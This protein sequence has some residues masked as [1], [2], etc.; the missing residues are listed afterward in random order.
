[1][2]SSDYTTGIL[3]FPPAD[4]VHKARHTIFGHRVAPPNVSDIDRGV[5][6]PR[7]SSYY[8]GVSALGTRHV[9]YSLER[10]PLADCLRRPAERTSTADAAEEPSYTYRILT[11]PNVSNTITLHV[12][13]TPGAQKDRFTWSRNKL[14]VNA[15]LV[16]FK[17]FQRPA[18]HVQNV[19]VQTLDA[20]VCAPRSVAP[21]PPPPTRTRP[22]VD[23]SLRIDGPDTDGYW[24]VEMIRRRLPIWLSE[25][26][27]HVPLEYPKRTR[28]F[29]LDDLTSITPCD[30]ERAYCRMYDLG[31]EYQEANEDRSPGTLCFDGAP[32]DEEACLPPREG[33]LFTVNTGVLTPPVLEQAGAAKRS[34][35]YDHAMHM[36]LGP[37]DTLWAG[38]LT[39]KPRVSVYGHADDPETPLVRVNV[40]PGRYVW[41]ATDVS[42]RLD[43]DRRRF[44]ARNGVECSACRL[45][46]CNVKRVELMNKMDE[47]PHVFLV[48]ED[49][50][51]ERDTV[52]RRADWT[53][54]PFERFVHLWACHADEFE[55]YPKTPETRFKHNWW[56]QIDGYLD[57]ADVKLKWPKNGAAGDK[58]CR[59]IDLRDQRF[60]Q[61]SRLVVKNPETFFGRRLIS[62]EI[63][64]GGRKGSAF[65]LADAATLEVVGGVMMDV[66]G[67][68][69][70]VHPK[71]EPDGRPAAGLYFTTKSYEK[72]SDV[73]R[74]V[75]DH[76][77][78]C[79]GGGGGR[80]RAGAALESPVSLGRTMQPAV[81]FEQL[82]AICDGTVEKTFRL[83][84]TYRPHDPFW[85][86]REQ[87]TPRDKTEAS[88][89]TTRSRVKRKLN[90]DE[91]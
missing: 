68:S 22:A 3:V 7:P 71:G 73:Q 25:A 62:F 5:Y 84:R 43:H 54:R 20:R 52:A 60:G 59:K 34:V 91:Y 14:A 33:R 81:R 18:G 58:R 53:E 72:A 66:R 45:L 15:P 4:F 6:V 38:N 90:F 9:D 2:D 85:F 11:F 1:M 87:G 44:F 41:G 29:E 32:Y 35:L 40:E 30:A 82:P 26:S 67:A 27:T 74:L 19:I 50:C 86:A 48:K 70:T 17:V 13:R 69:Y 28:A 64:N 12:Y 46:Q 89:A 51:H 80:Q 24:T 31:R 75:L 23:T 47:T 36:E 55:N 65:T 78:E 10:V 37:R 39:Y 56:K 77:T 57:R 42:V 49:R 76:M 21:L 16:E 61:A 63:A 88:F 79:H 8:S 83:A